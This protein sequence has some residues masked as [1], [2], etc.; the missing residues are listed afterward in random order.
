MSEDT[1]KIAKVCLLFVPMG[2]VSG[3]DSIVDTQTSSF[4]SN[5]NLVSCS[6]LV[7]KR[8]VTQ[9]YTGNYCGRSCGLS[10]LKSFAKTQVTNIGAYDAIVG[11]ANVCSDGTAGCSNGADTLWI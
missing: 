6:D 3:F 8:K 2:S 1:I 4:V 10:G 7:I 5:T 11:I 9:A